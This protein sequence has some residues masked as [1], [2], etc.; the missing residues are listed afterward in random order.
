MDGLFVAALGLFAYG[1]YLEHE[2]AIE[3]VR[4]ERE[5]AIEAL[6]ERAERLQEAV[7]DMESALRY[8]PQAHSEKQLN[9]ARRKADRAEEALLMARAGVQRN[10]D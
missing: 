2:S 5:S 1:T 3:R 4:E 10:L 7:D 6:R 9:A 8:D